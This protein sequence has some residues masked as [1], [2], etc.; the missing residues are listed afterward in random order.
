MKKIFKYLAIGIIFLSVSAPAFAQ[1]IPVS[2]GVLTFFF[3]V[4]A[5]V[6]FVGSVLTSKKPTAEVLL[7]FN[8]FGLGYTA[9]VFLRALYADENT[10]NLLYIMAWFVFNI[11]ANIKT[12]KSR[13]NKDEKG[14]TELM[15]AAE[16]GEMQVV[17]NLIAAGA[18]INIKDDQGKTALDYAKEN[19]HSEIIEFLTSAQNAKK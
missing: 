16:R 9:I 12:I 13:N 2:T 5:F 1:G 7:G 6:C 19:N 17:V 14:K 3:F 18:D 15:R 11:L 8:V 10:S 4:W